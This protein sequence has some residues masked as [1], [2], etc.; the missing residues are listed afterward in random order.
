MSVRAR[1]I[2]VAACTALALSLT[3]CG[4]GDDSGDEPQDGAGASPPGG[5]APASPDPSSGLK[6][7]PSDPPSTLPRAPKVKPAQVKSIVGRWVGPGKDY[8]VF[9]SD[10][11][12]SWVKASTTLWSGQ[13][14]P[15]GKDKYRFSWQGGDPK[16]ASYWGVSLTDGGTKLLFAGTN[17]SYSKARS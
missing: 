8:F 3:G 2:L 16:S 4:S 10:G 12:G 6:D 11:T 1:S 5:Q 13:V 7:L 14:I 15:E 17:Q 9:K